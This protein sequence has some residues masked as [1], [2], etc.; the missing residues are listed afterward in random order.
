MVMDA[1]EIVCVMS[2]SRQEEREL[3][4]KQSDLE[5]SST[6]KIFV[7]LLHFAFDTNHK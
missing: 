5:P 6:M 3:M 4:G 1:A 7:D 2:S